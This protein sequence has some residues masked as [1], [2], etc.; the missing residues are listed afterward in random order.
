MIMRTIREAISFINPFFLKGVDR[1]LPAG[2][3]EVVTGEELIGGDESTRRAD[4]NYQIRRRT[5]K[6]TMMWT[7]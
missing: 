7:P 2:S 4:G 5:G 6:S 3:Y 1:I